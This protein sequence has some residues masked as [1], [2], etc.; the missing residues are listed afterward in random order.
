MKLKH[1]HC[2]VT[3]VNIVYSG[4][5]WYKYSSDGTKTR[6]EEVENWIKQLPLKAG[7]VSKSDE[8]QIGS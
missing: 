7:D 6:D 4:R 2:E 1:P 5:G 8:V 3:T